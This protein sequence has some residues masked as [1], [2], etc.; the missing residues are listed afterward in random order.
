MMSF[1]LGCNDDTFF[2]VF[3]ALMVQCWLF[4]N[5]TSAGLVS[6]DVQVPEVQTKART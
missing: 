6:N 1:P 4:N 2:V 5:S 3:S